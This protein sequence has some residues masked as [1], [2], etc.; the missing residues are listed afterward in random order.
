MKASVLN[1]FKYPSSYD[2]PSADLIKWPLLKSP[3]FHSRVSKFT[4]N[5][6]FMT[7]EV[8]TLLQIQ[9]IWGAIISDFC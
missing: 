3:D 5:L 8:D 6:P 4:K 7:L 2:Q 9:K 1:S